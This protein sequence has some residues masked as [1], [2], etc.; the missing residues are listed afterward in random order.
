MEYKTEQA[1]PGNPVDPRYE[2]LASKIVMDLIITMAADG[3]LV[4]GMRVPAAHWKDIV[5]NC[6]KKELS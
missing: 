4:T 1:L 5:L 3:V 6:I 2:S